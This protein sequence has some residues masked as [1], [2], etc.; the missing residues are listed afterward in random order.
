MCTILYWFVIILLAII[1]LDEMLHV[2]V[3]MCGTLISFQA[4]LTPQTLTYS[5]AAKHTHPAS[6]FTVLYLYTQ[7]HTLYNYK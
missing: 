7:S 3:V 6:A 1:H 2:V 5:I 4:V